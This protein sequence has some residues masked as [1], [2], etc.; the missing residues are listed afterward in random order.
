MY[1]FE[2]KYFNYE[3]DKYRLQKIEI[4]GSLF[5]NEVEI[6]MHAMKVAYEFT[7]VNEIFDLIQIIAY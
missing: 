5:E 3:T 1:L 6:Y 2:A 7:N 4:D